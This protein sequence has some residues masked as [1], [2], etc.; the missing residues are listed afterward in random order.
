MKRFSPQQLRELRERVAAIDPLLVEAADDVDEALLDYSLSM[1]P[2]ERL[3][4]ATR[5][6]HGLARFRRLA[7][8]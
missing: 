7:P 2:L 6:A 1:R 8:E 3:G 4:F 5:S